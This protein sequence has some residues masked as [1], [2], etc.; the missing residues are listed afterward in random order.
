MTRNTAV[1]KTSCVSALTLVYL[2]IFFGAL[3][4]GLKGGYIYN[5]FPLMGNGFIPPEVDFS[6][7]GMSLNNPVFVQFMHR[8]IAYSLVLV[9]TY[10]MSRL[11]L[12]KEKNC[13]RIAFYIGVALLIQ[14][15]TGIITLIYIV[16]IETAL[17]HQIGSIFLLS[18]LLYCYYFIKNA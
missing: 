10:L 4:A 6:I 12:S 3:L 1:L 11:Y 7:N 18:S 2:Q 8:I 5:N 14:I 16:P 17:L 9:I 15:A 13:M